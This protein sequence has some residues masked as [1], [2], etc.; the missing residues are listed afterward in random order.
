MRNHDSYP[1]IEDDDL[2]M[3]RLPLLREVLPQGD[4]DTEAQDGVEIMDL[5]MDGLGN[6]W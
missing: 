6:R 4:S 2:P 1:I 5:G 3:V